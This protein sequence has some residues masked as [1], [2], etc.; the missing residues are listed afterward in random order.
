MFAL[1]CTAALI[2]VDMDKES[3]WTK[4][5]VSLFAFYV[6]SVAALFLFL[7]TFL[8]LPEGN[9]RI[10]DTIIG[11]L[12]GSVIGPI[13]VWAFRSSK[14]QVDREEQERIVQRVRADDTTS[15]VTM[16]SQTERSD[17]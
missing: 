16:T 4:N 9:Q 8:S 2:G 11:F 7:A 6:F 17:K 12:L 5:F 3:I 14:A 1:E 15:K 10:V 13:V